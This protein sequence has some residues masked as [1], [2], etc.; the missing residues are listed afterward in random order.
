MYLKKLYSAFFVCC[1]PT[2][3]APMECNAFETKTELANLTTMVRFDY[4][5]N[6]TDWETVKSNS[7]FEGKYLMFKLE[8]NIIDGLCYSWRQRLNKSHGDSNFFDATDWLYLDY[9]YKCFSFSAGKQVVGIGGWEY[10]RPPID[11]YHSSL[12][13]QN[14][15]CFQVGASVRYHF[16]KDN[17]LMAQMNESPFYNKENR[18]LYAYNILWN[19]KIGI[20]KSIWSANIIEYAPSH[21]IN[22]LTLGN[23]FE[24]NNKFRLEADFMNRASEHQTFLFRDCSIIAELRFSPNDRWGISGKYTYDVNRTHTAADLTVLSG[25]ELNMA[26]ASIEYYPLIKDRTSLRVHLS[27]YYSWGI[28]KNEADVMQNKS[29]LFNVGITWNM[30][31]FSLKR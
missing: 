25:S 15:S 18:D 31:I 13:W 19:G 28:N 30:N 10:D 2:V 11:L 3:L 1:L 21:Y 29:A 22:Y 27:G 4:Q 23:R 12:F 6:Y 26:G 14:I 5:R 7:G 16:S 24:F 9:R 8:G 17:S 20:F